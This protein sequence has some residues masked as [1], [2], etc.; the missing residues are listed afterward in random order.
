MRL[1]QMTKADFKAIK[2]GLKQYAKLG[3]RFNMYST[4]DIRFY[5]DS[6][7]GDLLGVKKMNE[8][9]HGWDGQFEN[10][11]YFENKNNNIFNTPTAY[12]LIF[13]DTSETKIQE[14]KEG[15]VVTN[16]YWLN[17]GTP[18]FIMLGNTRNVSDQL[19][20]I[21]G[22]RKTSSASF[23]DC[24]QNGFKIV[25][26]GLTKDEVIDVLKIKLPTFGNTLTKKDI[27]AEKD[28]HKLVS[29]MM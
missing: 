11:V 21:R 18:G 28:L 16:T 13:Q 10:G 26:V 29:K 2:N 14:M 20:D 4:Q 1:R 5:K 22:S 7:V 23:T 27:Y 3:D 9:N 8:S 25:A 15:V 24:F 17:A 12:R 19:S 6:I